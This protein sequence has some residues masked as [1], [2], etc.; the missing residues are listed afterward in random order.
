V[1][2]KYPCVKK[3]VAAIGP[4]ASNTNIGAGVGLCVCGLVSERFTGQGL[5]WRFQ[6]D[7]LMHFLHALCEERRGVV[8]SHVDEAGQLADLRVIDGEIGTAWAGRWEI[9]ERPTVAQTD[10]I[11]KVRLYIKEE[12]VLGNGDGG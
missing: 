3:C 8:V 6:F 5:E 1:W 11:V 10:V 12:A 2:V 4:E 9:V 7:I